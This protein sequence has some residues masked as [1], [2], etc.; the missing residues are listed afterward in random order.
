VVVTCFKIRRIFQR[1]PERIT[2]YL[3]QE[4]ES[5]ERDCKL[6]FWENVAFWENGGDLTITPRFQSVW[7]R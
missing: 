1:V 3:S 5:L 6:A 7:K 2:K 4:S